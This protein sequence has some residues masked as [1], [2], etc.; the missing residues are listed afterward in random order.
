MDE[1]VL[2]IRPAIPERLDLAAGERQPHLQAILDEVVVIRLAVGG[3]DL[4]RRI[5]AL[6]LRPHGIEKSRCGD[7]VSVARADLD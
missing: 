1:R 2:E 3:D 4:V 5:A 7:P 6:L